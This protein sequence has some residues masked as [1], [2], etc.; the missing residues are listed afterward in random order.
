MSQGADKSARR[1]VGGVVYFMFAK[2]YFMAAGY[3]VVFGLPRAF[4]QALQSGG[5]ELEAAQAG[6]V[7]LYG[8]FGIVNSAVAVLNMILIDGIRYT[9]SKF[10]ASDDANAASIR[11]AALVL[12]ALIGGGLALGDRACS[13]RPRHSH[14][15]GNVR[16][17]TEAANQ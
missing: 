9:V 1:A 17:T 12:Q 11:R 10:V 6:A 2:V 3:A 15:N 8:D 4:R 16:R 14:K 5:L 7:A 13:A